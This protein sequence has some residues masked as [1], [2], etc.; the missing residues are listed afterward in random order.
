MADKKAE[1]EKSFNDMGTVVFKPKKR[2]FQRA[3][4][5]AVIELDGI[6]YEVNFDGALRLKLPAKRYEYFCYGV[7]PDSIGLYKEGGTFILN[8]DETMT[9]LYKPSRFRPLR[10]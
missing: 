6:K 10:A 3:Y 7:R 2:I 9:I 8:D 4:T 1:R 5:N